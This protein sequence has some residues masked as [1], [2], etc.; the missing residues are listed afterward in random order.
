MLN[1]IWRYVKK[2]F[3]ELFRSHKKIFE[4]GYQEGRNDGDI[5]NQ[6]Y[7]EYMRILKKEFPSLMEY[8]KDIQRYCAI[9]D[10][11]VDSL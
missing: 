2:F 8:I 11:D 4:E 9:Y 10:V 7:C 5:K 6:V 3:T 1:K